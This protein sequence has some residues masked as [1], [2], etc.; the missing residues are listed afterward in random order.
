M[1]TEQKIELLK[2]KASRLQR[3][4]DDPQPGLAMWSIAVGKVLDE[5]A[6]MAPNGGKS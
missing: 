1:T 2:E 5:I 4:L 3:L 6:E